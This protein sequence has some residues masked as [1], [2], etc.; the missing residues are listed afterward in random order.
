MDE[1]VFMEE[2]LYR[3]STNF[4]EGALRNLRLE[5]GAN[6]LGLQL[7]EVVLMFLRPAL[8]QQVDWVN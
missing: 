2:E 1:N 8:L 6:A 3:R 7:S 4:F 5:M